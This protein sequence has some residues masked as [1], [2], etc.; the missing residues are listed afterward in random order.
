VR[1]HGWV[2]CLD[3]DFTRVLDDGKGKVSGPVT[4][5]SLFGLFDEILDLFFFIFVA[6]EE[7]LLLPSPFLG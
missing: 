2:H 7:L 6:S 1:L 5:N 4:D 3:V